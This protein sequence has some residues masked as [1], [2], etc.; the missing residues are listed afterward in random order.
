MA[1]R[2]SMRPPSLTPSFRRNECH[3]A[4]AKAIHFDY[5][6]SRRTSSRVRR[7]DYSLMYI[8]APLPISTCYTYVN[9]VIPLQLRSV[10]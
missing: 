9:G 2:G 5:E 1:K 3:R 8:L 10:I 4:S 6:G 7:F